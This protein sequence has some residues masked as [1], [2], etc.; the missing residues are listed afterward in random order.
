MFG[1][2]VGGT[3]LS[4]DRSAVPNS[5]V[6]RATRIMFDGSLA[7]AAGRGKAVRLQAALLDLFGDARDLAIFP[8]LSACPG[9]IHRMGGSGPG[10]NG[11]HRLVND[12]TPG[13]R[14]LFPLSEIAPRARVERPSSG[15]ISVDG[16]IVDAHV[17]VAARV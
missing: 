16:L 15:S 13:A 9:G 17:L 4:T 6:V 10:Q 11:A 5:R 14:S 7:A 1:S 2:S 3:A 8:S 12:Y